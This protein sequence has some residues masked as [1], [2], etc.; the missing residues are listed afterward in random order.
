MEPRKKVKQLTKTAEVRKPRLQIVKLEQRI[1]PQEVTPVPY[2]GRLLSSNHNEK[3]V[4]DKAKAKPTVQQRQ[5][6]GP[7]QIV[8]LEKRIAPGIR[9][10]H[11]ETLFR[12]T[13]KVPAVCNKKPKRKLQIVKLEQRIA[14]GI[15]LNHNETLVREEAKVAV[16]RCKKPKLKL[17]IV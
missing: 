13:E 3:L 7:L 10:N 9:L 16:V 1:T 6:K 12:E 14:P 2:V 8:N 4:R 15:R 17:R 5:K 11:N